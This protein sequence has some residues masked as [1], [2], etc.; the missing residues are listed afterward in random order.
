MV[1]LVVA[2]LAI[3]AE[4]VPVIPCDSSSTVDAVMVPAIELPPII[5]PEPPFI[6]PLELMGITLCPG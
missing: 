1:K 6:I 5:P 3:A 4:A 2:P